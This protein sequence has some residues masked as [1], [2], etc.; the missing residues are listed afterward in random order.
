[1]TWPLKVVIGDIIVN[2]K[3]IASIKLEG[4]E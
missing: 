2:P 1:M 3:G 4:E